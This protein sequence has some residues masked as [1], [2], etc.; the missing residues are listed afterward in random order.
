MLGVELFAENLAEVSL[1]CGSAVVTR[2]LHAAAARADD[3]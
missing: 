3:S 1:H 2:S